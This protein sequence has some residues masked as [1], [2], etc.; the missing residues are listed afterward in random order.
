MQSQTITGLQEQLSNF[1]ASDATRIQSIQ[2]QVKSLEGRINSSTEMQAERITRIE[3]QLG[4]LVST[5]REDSLFTGSLTV[6]ESQ[7]GTL[8]NTVKLQRVRVKEA[9]TSIT[10]M[11]EKLQ[12]FNDNCITLD[13]FKDFVAGLQL[14]VAKKDQV[15]AQVASDDERDAKFVTIN[16]FTEVCS[17]ITNKVRASLAFSNRWPV[18]FK[19]VQDPKDVQPR[20]SDPSTSRV[21]LRRRRA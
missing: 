6:M 7:L 20:K 1:A 9:L 3:A 12:Y 16:E 11:Q 14:G 17:S 21:R 18:K 15:Q 19:P 4:G 8:E 10:D 5:K 13:E 2:V